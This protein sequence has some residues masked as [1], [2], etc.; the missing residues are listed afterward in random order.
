MRGAK[1]DER[2]I[3]SLRTSTTKEKV[4]DTFKKFGIT[5]LEQK[6]NCLDE[7]MYSP[8]VFYSAGENINIDHKYEL[9]L[10]MFLKGRWKLFTL[11]QK[12]EPE[13][14]QNVHTR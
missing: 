9:A 6:I 12:I 14:K 10:Q 2:L 11:Y 1:T 4:E 5:K 8:E 3:A 7:A 13:L